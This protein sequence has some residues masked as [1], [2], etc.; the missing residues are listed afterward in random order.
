MLEQ[1]VCGK[2]VYLFSILY[3]TKP[4]KNEVYEEKKD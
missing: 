1:E 4:S 3:E 2:S